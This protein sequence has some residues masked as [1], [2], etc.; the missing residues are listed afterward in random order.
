M[1]K[2]IASQIFALLLIL[3]ASTVYADSITITTYFP[4][5]TGT[6]NN[7]KVNQAANPGCDGSTDAIIFLDSTSNE[8]K[9]CIDEDGS[10]ATPSRTI[11]I[12]GSCFNRFCSYTGTLQ[13]PPACL[14][15]LSCPTGYTSMGIFDDVV[16]SSAGSNHMVSIACCKQIHN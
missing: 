4:L 7:I 16:T 12:P 3:L 13:S 15:T 5:P 6:Y 8:L 10:G 2:H 1:M 11:S 14:A 9:A